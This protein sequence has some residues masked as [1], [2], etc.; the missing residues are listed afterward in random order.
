[1]LHIPG[2]INIFASYLEGSDINVARKSSIIFKQSIES[3]ESQPKYFED[4]LDGR[5]KN[6]LLLTDI[7]TK[8][9]K[10]YNLSKGH[11]TF[12]KQIATDA[13]R[14]QICIDFVCYGLQVMES[15]FSKYAYDKQTDIPKKRIASD[16]AS[17]SDDD[18]ESSIK[19]WDGFD[20]TNDNSAALINVITK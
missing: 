6:L 16:E 11:K 15:Y 18:N 2:V 12:F 8:K 14:A 20:N 3:V 9:K 1:M 19:S 17:N 5:I 13:T 10:L 7:K 4:L